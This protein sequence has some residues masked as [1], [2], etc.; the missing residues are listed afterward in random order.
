MRIGVVGLGVIATFYLAAVER[1]PSVRLVAVCDV[2]D[3]ALTPHRERLACYAD[4]R[5]L[6]AHPGLDAVV[7]TV[8]NDAHGPVCRDAINAGIPVCVEKPLCL[9]I[10]DGTELDQ[11][12]Q[13]HGVALFTAFHRRYNAHLLS[14]VDS[15]AGAA[16]VESVRVRYLERIEEHIGADAWYLDPARCGGGCVADNGPNVFDI[17]RTLLG[18]LTVEGA[19][20]GWDATGVDRQAVV[21][22]RGGSGA[23]ARVELDWSYRGEA[24]DV[25]VHLA[26]G[27]VHRADLLAGHPDFKGSLWHEYV[28][29]LAEFT[30]VVCGAG[31]GNDGLA[32]LTLVHATYR[33]AAE[34]SAAPVRKR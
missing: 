33:I 17:V 13:Q 11:L 14:L 2:D 15:L 30:R 5:S 29:I 19:W 6:L 16:P 32:A 23:Q 27:S 26:D 3:A 18:D 9:S 24:K 4:H 25:E 22:L 12:A 28:G 20:I 21:L 10:E 8:P 31:T 1:L 7:V 34:R